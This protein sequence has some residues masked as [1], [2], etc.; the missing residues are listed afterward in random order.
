MDFS[1]STTSLAHMGSGITRM[2]HWLTRKLDPTMNS[3]SSNVQRL[4]IVWVEFYLEL[5]DGTSSNSDSARCRKT[6]Y[7]MGHLAL[8]KSLGI[9]LSKLIWTS[10]WMSKPRAQH[11]YMLR[12]N[13]CGDSTI[14]KKPMQLPPFFHMAPRL[15]TPNYLP[16]PGISHWQPSPTWGSLP[17]VCMPNM[18]PTTHRCPR[19]PGARC[20]PCCMRNVPQMHLT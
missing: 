2:G 19:V 17:P 18:P 15:A 16:V 5:I 14:R 10:V 9:E 6:E 4:V 7:N 1:A 12:L 20:A 8:A 13:L 3:N 11:S